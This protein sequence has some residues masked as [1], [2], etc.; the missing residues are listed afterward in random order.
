MME[1][2]FYFVFFYPLFMAF[3]WMIGSLLFFF[4]HER[5]QTARPELSEH[6]HVAILVPCHNEAADIRATLA[7]LSRNHYP[8]FEIVAV[9]DGSTDATGAILDELAAREPRLRVIHLARNYGKAMA[10]RAAALASRAEFLM[11]IDADTLLDEDAIFWMIGHMLSGPRVG[12][13]TGNPRIANRGTLLARI[14]V[15]EFSSIIGMV[16]RS[17]R[18]VGRVFTVSGCHVCF[19]RRALHEVGYWSPETVTEDIDVSWKLQLHYWDVRFEPRALARIDMPQT[20]RGLWRQRLRWARGGIEAALKYRAL[21]R[22]W[23]KRRMWPVYVE[24]SIG[25]AW[26]YAWAFTVLCWLATMLFPAQWP[27]AMQVETLLPRWTGVILGVTC[28]LQFLV[29]L[30]LDSHYE[31]GIVRNI[32]W[33]IWYPAVYWMISSCATIVAIPK[34]LFQRGRVRYATWKSPERGVS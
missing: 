16:K 13:V 9:D 18:D 23:T 12:A 34:T 24:Y 5:N 3:F 4:R 10:L 32:F 6:P 8:D 20:L 19:R 17:Q 22:D 2:V 29:G 1:A 14:Q 30:Y 25:A 15:G 28:L 21:L 7:Q 33:A 11:C 27:A 31:K 26:C